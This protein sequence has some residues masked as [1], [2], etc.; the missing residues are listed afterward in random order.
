MPERFAKEFVPELGPQDPGRAFSPL[1]FRGV[2]EDGRRVGRGR[3]PAFGRGWSVGEPREYGKLHR[4]DETAS[5]SPTLDLL[6]LN[7]FSG[8]LSWAEASRLSG[9]A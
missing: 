5:L 6:K 9:L 1:H 2:V 7:S 3:S 8:H 4:D